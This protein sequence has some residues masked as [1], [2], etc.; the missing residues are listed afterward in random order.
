MNAGRTEDESG[1]SD[2]PE[3][4][5]RMHQ[6]T[7]NRGEDLTPFVTIDTLLLFI[8]TPMICIPSDAEPTESRH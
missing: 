3:R 2:E 1:E 8:F 7:A 6:K 4:E 5:M